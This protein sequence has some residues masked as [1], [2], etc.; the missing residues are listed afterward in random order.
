MP[1]IKESGTRRSR[2]HR[3]PRPRGPI[4]PLRSGHTGRDDDLFEVTPATIRLPMKLVLNDSAATSR[5]VRTLRSTGAV[6]AP[7]TLEEVQRAG[8]EI[9]SSLRD[10]FT[11]GDATAVIDLLRIDPLFIRVPWVREALDD[12]ERAD[13]F[14]RPRGRGR[15]RGVTPESYLIRSVIVALVEDRTA[16]TGNSAEKVFDE[17]AGRRFENL[18]RDTIKLYYYNTRRDPRF[19][20]FLIADEAKVR[21]ETRRELEARLRNL[22]MSPLNV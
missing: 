1:R 5:A 10:R 19:A 20:S 7:T 8:D 14:T 12:L 13:Y 4:R 22:T 17:L 18:K 9:P 2:G 6:S 15:P 16:R 21:I 11:R 3:S